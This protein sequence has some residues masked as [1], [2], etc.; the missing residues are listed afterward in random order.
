VRLVRFLPAAAIVLAACDQSTD[1]TTNLV[2]DSTIA[3]DVAA[4]AG[5]A[6]ASALETM[7]G[8]EASMSLPGSNVRDGGAALTTNS[9]NITRSRTC[10]DA[11]GA[12][13]AGCSPL[14]A[15]RRIVTSASVDG[16]RSGTHTKQN[17]VTVTWSGAVHRASSDTVV[18]HFTGDTETS[19]T[20]TGVGAGHDTSTFSDGNV[21]RFFAEATADSVK[22]LTWN[23][24]RAN[25][26]FPVAGSI[27]RV[28][29][30]HVIATRGGETRERKVV[31]TVRVDFPADAQGNVALHINELTCNLN[32]VTRVVSNC[33]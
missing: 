7:A 30:V 17:G 16:T 31:W 28:D 4:S 3:A 19:R 6:I 23:I 18:R 29:S 8:N 11:M 13:L 14:S 2:S 27:I 15:V 21:S 24:P 32:L 22:G 26:P 25:N 1:P 33:Q 20:H 5:D 12:E 10:Y 9:L